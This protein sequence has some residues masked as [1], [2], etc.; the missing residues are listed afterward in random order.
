MWSLY[1]MADDVLRCHLGSGGSAGFAQRHSGCRVTSSQVFTKSEIPAILE[2][3]FPE[4]K[5]Y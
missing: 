3:G 5:C 4:R 1:S 2:N